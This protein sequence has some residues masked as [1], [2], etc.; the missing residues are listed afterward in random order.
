[1]QQ[2][3][4]AVS[5][6]LPA[7]AVEPVAGFLVELSGSGVV[8]DN[9]N[10]DTFS[11]ADLAE[12]ESTTVTAYFPADE[13][14]SA[15]MARIDEFLRQEST[16]ANQPIPKPQISVIGEEEWSDSWKIHFKTTRIGR[17]LIIKPSWEEFTASA[18]DIVLELDPGMAFGTGS[19]ATTRLCLEAL[20]EIYGTLAVDSPRELLD[21]GCGSGILAI[22]GACLG[23]SHVV[24]IDIDPD[25][26]SATAANALANGVG[27]K[28]VAS[29]TP[30]EEVRGEFAV[31]VA[32]I[33]AEELVRLS[34]PLVERLARGGYLVL[35]G[36]LLE[37]E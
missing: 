18:N 11:L 10:V 22:A 3:W 2:K 14:L 23:A 24:A 15:T 29:A 16:L 20:E 8:T 27:E 21:V 7:A 37:K 25:S 32:N 9:R 31:V 34:L 35:S 13:G 33:L 4:T 12:P 26:V 17:H 5:L 1:M 30:L 36:I 28:V 19:H 6:L